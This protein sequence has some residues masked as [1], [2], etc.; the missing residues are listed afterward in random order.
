MIA[1]DAEATLAPCLRSVKGLVDRMVLVDTGSSD[2]T[3]AL[4]RSL[5]ATVFVFPWTND[6]AAARNAA[7]AAIDTDW[8][9]VLD[10]DE[11]LDRAA[12]TWIR[13]ELLAPKAEGYIVPVRNY[14]QPW[15]EPAIR[16]GRL[17]PGER[18]PRAPD[19]LIY[20]ES[21]VCRL[22]RRDPLVYYVGH[23][24]EQVEYRLLE[25]GRPIGRAGFF[26]HH[27]GWYL[28]EPVALDRKR[29]LYLDLLARKLGERPDDNQVRLQYGDALLHWSDRS[30]EALECF[31]EA[32]RRKPEDPEVW[33]HLANALLKSAQPEAA[34]IAIAQAKLDDKD[35]GRAAQ[36]RGEA[37]A[38]LRRW[39]EARDAFRSALPH[40]PGYMVLEARLALME[41]FAGDAVGDERMQRV[42]AAAEVEA[43]STGHMAVL[44]RAAELRMHRSQ[45]S[46]AL[47]WLDRAREEARRMG[48][49]KPLLE[50][51]HKRLQAAVACGRFAEAAESAASIA[52]LDPSPKAVLRQVAILVQAGM[53]EKALAAVELGLIRFPEAPRLLQALGELQPGSGVCAFDSLA[54]AME[55]GSRG[56]GESAAL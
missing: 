46:Q 26:I 4:A 34:L 22:F 21:A 11:E 5:G 23:V 24:H 2:S 52:E 30:A 36:L 53:H 20:G 47:Q 44:T 29:A 18:H 51:D 31:L 40:F 7:L 19:A 3:V 6:F 48:G 10:A 17:P 14:L 25:L 55:A 50:I 16:Y 15:E 43:E 38:A 49:G 12:Y 39:P 56:A 41:I 35:Q 54:S 28:I 37:C 8:V 13:T 32:A 45:W 33:F 1:K 42:I 9:L 27:F